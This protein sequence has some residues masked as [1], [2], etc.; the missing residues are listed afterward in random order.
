MQAILTLE[1]AKLLAFLASGASSLCCVSA[2]FKEWF[3]KDNT[4]YGDVEPSLKALCM[5]NFVLSNNSIIPTY[6]EDLLKNAC[7]G[8]N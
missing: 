5:Q 6:G 3:I 1:I 8:N 7:L 2:A 4:I